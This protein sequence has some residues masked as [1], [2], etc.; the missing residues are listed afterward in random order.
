MEVDHETMI[1]HFISLFSRLVCLCLLVDLSVAGRF[2]PKD[3]TCFTSN[4]EMCQK[5]IPYHPTNDQILTSP[6][7]T[8]LDVPTDHRIAL[9]PLLAL[10]V[11]LVTA[12][13]STSRWFQPHK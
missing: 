2:E 3:V 6:E 8:E 7:F 13:A 4:A 5:L 12:A 1:L 10:E 9:V 11:A